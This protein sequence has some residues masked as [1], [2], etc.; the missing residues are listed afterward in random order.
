MAY[1][2]YE[3]IWKVAEPTMRKARKSRIDVTCK[4]RFLTWVKDHRN[5]EVSGLY[6]E[7]MWC[8]D[9]LGYSWEELCECVAEG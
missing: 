5:D 8:E 1:A 3:W 6:G 2:T 7:F 4:S 9:Q